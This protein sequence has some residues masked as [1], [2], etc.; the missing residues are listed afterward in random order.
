MNND[1][2]S[3]DGSDRDVGR[4]MPQVWSMILLLLS[5]MGADKNFAKFPLLFPQTTGNEDA[6]TDWLKISRLFGSI[7]S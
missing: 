4:W 2:T 3:I 6:L 7:W 1:S 5:D